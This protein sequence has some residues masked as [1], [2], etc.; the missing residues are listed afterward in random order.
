MTTLILNAD[1]QP[2]NLVPLSVL[3]WQ[4]AIK[5]MVLEKATVVS[6]YEDWWIHSQHWRTQV[7]AVL[8]LREYQKPKHAVRLTKRN[9]YLRDR[10]V[11]QYC[12]MK[13]TDKTASVD[14]V[15]PVSQGGRNRWENLTTACRKCNSLKS[16]K[17]DWQ[18]R[19]KPYRPTYW[20]L[21][22]L[23]RE[24]GYDIKHPSWLQ[25]IETC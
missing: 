18:P 14:H 1:A 22:N 19:N 9:V 5:Y 17:R 24:Q 25:F 7:P 15:I 11:C 12:D 2:K 20:E 6:Y 10:F 3:P 13:I 8:M 16:D 21:A 4:E 23:R